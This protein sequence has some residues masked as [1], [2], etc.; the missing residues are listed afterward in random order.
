MIRGYD[1][2]EISEFD[3]REEEAYDMVIIPCVHHKSGAQGMAQLAVTT[4]VEEVL[5]YYYELICVKIEPAED[6]HRDN[7]FLTYNGGV[8]T[9]IY[10][11][12]KESLS[13]GKIQ[14][15]PPNEYRIVISSI[16][17]RLLQEIERRNVVKDL[18]HTM[19]KSEKYYE[20]M[21]TK[22]AMA[23]H[24]TIKQLSLNQRWSKDHLR[25]IGN[26]QEAPQSLKIAKNA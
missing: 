22:D 14:P 1:E 23:A 25:I 2:L 4:D 6:G 18:S 17:Q 13:V 8:Y 20:I 10:R 3:L 7:L 16:A 24:A 11:K 5:I 9:Q 19:K 15:P 12:I 21:N 26:F